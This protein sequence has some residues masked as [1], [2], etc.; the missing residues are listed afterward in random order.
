MLTFLET[1][2][3][4]MYRGIVGYQQIYNNILQIS[5]YDFVLH[6]RGG[7]GENVGGFSLGLGV[8]RSL[9]SRNKTIYAEEKKWQVAAPVAVSAGLL[10]YVLYPHPC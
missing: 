5:P 1:I 4:I 9:S 3:I 10:L 6:G 7:E 8:T 2:L